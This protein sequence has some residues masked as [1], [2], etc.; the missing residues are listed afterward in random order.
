MTNHGRSANALPDPSTVTST[1][2]K[3]LSFRIAVGVAILISCIPIGQLFWPNRLSTL[4]LGSFMAGLCIWWVVLWRKPTPARPWIL[5][6][7]AMTFLTGGELLAAPSN[8]I[9]HGTATMNSG[10]DIVCLAG[11]AL[12][13]L[14]L[15]D[16][17]HSRRGGL[18]PD[19]LI[20][21]ITVGVIGMFYV[22]TFIGLPALANHTLSGRGLLVVVAYPSVDVILFAALV[23]VLI[24]RGSSSAGRL[25]GAGNILWLITDLAFITLTHLGVRGGRWNPVLNVCWTAALLFFALAALHPSMAGLASGQQQVRRRQL[26]AWRLLIGVGAFLIPSALDYLHGGNVVDLCIITSGACLGALIVLRCLRLLRGRDAAERQ[27][28][29]R[30]AYFH[31]LATKSAEAT[32]VV[33][34]N[35]TLTDIGGAHD[36]CGDIGTTISDIW[37]NI[38]P[39]DQARVQATIDESTQQPGHTRGTELRIRHATRGWLWL[40]ARFTNL[41]ADPAVGGYVINLYDI[42]RQKVAES[43]LHYR[44]SHDTLTALGNRTYFTDHLERSLSSYADEH[45]RVA[46][47]FLDVDG[48]KNVND[49]LGHAAGDEL[50]VT[51]AK[52]LLRTTQGSAVVARFGGDEF[53][54]LIEDG[55]HIEEDA[56][57]L[58]DKILE[59]LGEPFDIGG[60][61]IVIRASIG[62]AISGHEDTV[63]T[64]LRNSDLGMYQAKATGKGRVAIY[65]PDMHTAAHDRLYL[66]SELYGAAARGELRVAYQ[67]VTL[68]DGS[69]FSGF[70]ALV[71]WE[72]PLL[73]TIMPDRFIPIAEENGYISHIDAWVRDHALRTM[74]AW[75]AKYPAAATLRIAINLSGYGLVRG[76]IIADV[77]HSIRTAGLEP[78]SVVIEITESALVTSP[79]I[80]AKQLNGLRQ[81]GVQVAIDDFGTGFSSMAYLR[82]FDVDILKIDRS[83]VSAIQPDEHLPTLLQGL[84]D[85]AK[86]L[87]LVI[88]AEGI[89]TANQ[90]QQLQA[91]GCELGQGYFFSRPLSEADAEQYLV[92]HTVLTGV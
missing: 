49:G 31:A 84:L 51:V 63:T 33:A 15:L 18:N 75:H 72:H 32:V 64:L 2:T 54:A 30:E 73:G 88:V 12:L 92:T 1:D 60:Q 40:G 37:A 5:F 91:A 66:E 14:G 85:L 4:P 47:L 77:A 39:D 48:F 36:L 61:R 29:A 50:L 52:R 44:A 46:V 34:A 57:T 89:E 62:I 43:E 27:L 67:P 22:V 26:S 74:A 10:S 90:Y 59:V 70:E 79:D 28:L 35:G 55:D 3:G 56:Q 86:T 20:D 87:K 9:W 13:L 45:H 11:M 69:I 17:L 23:Y 53:A 6:A 76:D 19:T 25:M 21:M 78:T 41:T 82:Q 58:A 71:R 16:I 8:W 80:V 42:S 38:H 7:S 68:L 24:D 81:L 65:M 83:F